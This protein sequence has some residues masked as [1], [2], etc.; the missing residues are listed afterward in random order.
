[1]YGWIFNFA[2]RRSF[3]KLSHDKVQRM[4]GWTAGS[5]GDKCK[6]KFVSENR[7]PTHC[8]EFRELTWLLK[9]R[10]SRESAAVG[11]SGV[12]VHLE[13]DSNGE[14]D[15]TR[16]RRVSIGSLEPW[17]QPWNRRGSTPCLALRVDSGEAES[18]WFSRR[19]WRLTVRSGVIQF[20][21][22][23]RDGF[24]EF[25]ILRFFFSWLPV[26]RK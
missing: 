12:D 20:Y 9:F 1:M 21:S 13:D 25:E 6:K 17:D 5:S 26:I 24:P 15:E 2:K 11:D 22:F 4:F 10:F 3:D 7:K 8:L 18:T 16:Q 23:L 19:L 14:T